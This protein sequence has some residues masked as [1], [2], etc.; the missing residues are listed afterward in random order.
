MQ[1][2]TE[3]NAECGLRQC[4]TDADVALISRRLSKKAHND[5][6]IKTDRIDFNSESIFILIEITHKKSYL[7]QN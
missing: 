7:G 5:W 6:Y 1:L 3:K 4:Y 2:N